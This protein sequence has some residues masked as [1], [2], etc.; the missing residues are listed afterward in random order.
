MSACMSLAGALTSC[1]K[2]IFDDQGDCSVQYR[3]SFRYT[4][5]ILNADAFGSQVTDIN[6]ALY[7]SSGKMVY[8]KS[9]HRNP[10]IENE[11]Y[12][13]IEV[14]PGNYDIVAWCEG[15]S[16]NE[17]AES[18]TL[19]GQNIG[20]NISSSGAYLTLQERNG[21]YYS[22][23]DLNRLYY[24]FSKN[25]EFADSYGVIDIDPVYLTRDTNHITV[26]LQNMFGMP[27]DANMVSFE[28]EGRNSELNWQNLLEGDKAFTYTPWI[29]RPVFSDNPVY[30]EDGEDTEDKTRNTMADSQIPNGIQA[31]FTTS[32]LMAGVEQ[33]LTVRLKET[34]E[35]IL[36]IPMV[37]YLLLVRG[38]YEEAKSPQDYLDR[39]DDFSMLFFIDEGYNWI[40]SRVFINNWRVVP[41]QH[42]IL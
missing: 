34:G 29:V 7:D 26:Q 3:L 17:S 20:N 8:K 35:E 32:R 38:Y 39:Y 30:K 5:N 12:M 16:L 28:I 25:V 33:R 27:I 15:R 24:G 41:P 4:K 14:A 9:E 1:D 19:T 31:E 22:S 23:R 2:M 18:F 11:F 40:R 36:S 10:S 13:D 42:E 6:V 37:E 21:A